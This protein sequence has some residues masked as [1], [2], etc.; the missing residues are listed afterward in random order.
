MGDFTDYPYVMLKFALAFPALYMTYYEYRDL[1]GRVKFP[2]GGKERSVC[3]GPSPRVLNQPLWLW[4]DR[5][6][7]KPKPTVQSG[8]EKVWHTYGSTEMLT[9]SF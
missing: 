7:E 1:R 6:G 3:C 2:T 5:F 8:W 9:L 4:R